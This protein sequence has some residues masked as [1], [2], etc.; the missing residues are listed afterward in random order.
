MEK[1]YILLM[2]TNTLP[3]KMIQKATKYKYSHVVLSLEEDCKT[4]YS[5]G[6]KKLN[7]I[8]N[9][10]FIIEK[11]DGAF[12][13]KFNQTECRIYELTITKKQYQQIK[14]ILEFM[15]QNKE[16]YKYDFIG[17]FLRYWNIPINFK[18]HYV[19][20]YFVASLLEQ[21]NILHFN[22]KTAL[23]RPKDFEQLKS[24]QII[25]EGLYQNYKKMEE[26][27]ITI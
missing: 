17:L 23:V 22:K 27:L 16:K 6:R 8:L 12:F 10:G 9:C 3:A 1:I 26:N 14:E 5:F 4:V 24:S 21:T 13:Q 19:C 18:N 20:S 11:K 7:N 15:E 25:Y 2:H